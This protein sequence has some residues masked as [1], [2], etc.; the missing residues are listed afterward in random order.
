M[1]KS[2]VLQ[3]K[4]ACLAFFSALCALFL[5]GC[6]T[7]RDMTATQSPASTQQA[8]PSPQAQNSVLP[9]P[10]SQLKDGVYTA[11]VS[12][13]Y[14]QENHGWKEFVT[15]TVSGG[16]ITDVKYDAEKDGKMKRD[17]TESEFPMDPPPSQWIPQLEENIRMARDAEDIDAVAGATKS[18]NLVKKLYAAALNA[19]KNGDTAP[20]TLADEGTPESL[21]TKTETTNQQGGQE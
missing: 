13:A 16:Q 10:D 11:Q 5:M 7:V 2:S 8:S 4:K 3:K 15:L 9:S 21:S 12:D 19:A 18:S 14:A 1:K 20:V 17:A 6:S